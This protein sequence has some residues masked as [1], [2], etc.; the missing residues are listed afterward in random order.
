MTKI[1]SG[2]TDGLI[3]KAKVLKENNSLTNAISWRDSA[4]TVMARIGFL[5]TA[6]QVFSIAASAYNINIVGHSTV[7][8]GPAIKENGVLLSEKYA[9]NSKLNEAL[10]KKPIQQMCTLQRC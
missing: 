5:S 7:N 3:L 9:T 8:L 10:N 1:E 6:D 4:N 2:A